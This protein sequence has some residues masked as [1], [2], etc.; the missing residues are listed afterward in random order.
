MAEQQK[1]DSKTSKYNDRNPFEQAVIDYMASLL[2]PQNATQSQAEKKKNE[3]AGQ[4]KEAIQGMVDEFKIGLATGK[5]KDPLP[6]AVEIAEPLNTPP[7]PATKV[8]GK[9]TVK[10]K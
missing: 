6:G 8:N 10:G 3:L 7:Q 1:Q 5:I 4:D 9:G 2:L